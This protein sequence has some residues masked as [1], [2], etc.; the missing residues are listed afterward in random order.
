MITSF[1]IDLI[2]SNHTAMALDHMSMK[3]R[4]ACCS[5]MYRKALRLS[6]NA[7]AQ[8]TIGQ[9]VNL[10]SNDVSKFDEGFRLTHYTWISPVQAAIGTYLLYRIVGVSAF[11]GIAFLFLFVPLQSMLSKTQ[12]ALIYQVLF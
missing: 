2:I 9:I 5:L 1:T 6:K 7:L 8:T 12:I 4:V 10:L 11:A 3:M